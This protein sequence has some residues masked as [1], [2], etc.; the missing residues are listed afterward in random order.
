MADIPAVKAIAD[1][2]KRAL[3]FVHRASLTRAA[4]REELLVAGSGPSIVGFCQFY[5]RRDGTATIY[6]VA[7]TPEARRT[8]VGRA[9]IAEVA[10]DAAERGMHA[11]RLK[12]PADLSAN[13]FYARIGF[14]LVDVEAQRKRP[15]NVWE[16]CL[17]EQ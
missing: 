16:F 3:G 7:V 8:G 4:T 2:D 5:R 14:G 1:R 13:A 6:H 11:I 17:P 12:C 15:L 10:H 9:L